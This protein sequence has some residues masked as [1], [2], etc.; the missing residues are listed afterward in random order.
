MLCFTSS[1]TR[2]LSAEHYST[3]IIFISGMNKT[4]TTERTWGRYR[5]A[6][7]LSENMSE[8]KQFSEKAGPRPLGVSFC[9]A[10]TLMPLGRNLRSAANSS[11]LLIDMDPRAAKR[12]SGQRSTAR[13][14]STKQVNAMLESLTYVYQTGQCHARISH[15][16]EQHTSARRLIP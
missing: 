13:Y 15:W 8:N 3:Y 16:F 14:M 11:N 9:K 6:G 7:L 12:C 4:F 10:R 5:A 2:P 1:T